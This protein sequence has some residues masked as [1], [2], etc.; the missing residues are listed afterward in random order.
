MPLKRA[1]PHDVQRRCTR[2]LT[3]SLSFLDSL[4]PPKSGSLQPYPGGRMKSLTVRLLAISL[5]AAALS[6]P[7]QAA[8]TSLLARALADPA[9][10]AQ[11]E[12]DTRRHPAELVALADL[13]PDQRGALLIPPWCCLPWFLPH[14]AGQTGRRHAASAPRGGHAA[15]C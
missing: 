14:R 13:K 12:T 7:S 15:T 9:R 4:R 11:R 6:P 1:R 2:A 8:P 3:S 10:A 5:G